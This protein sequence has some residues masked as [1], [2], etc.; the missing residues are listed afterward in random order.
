MD[1]VAPRAR[2]VLMMQIK[3]LSGLGAQC[4]LPKLLQTPSVLSC[5]CSSQLNQGKDG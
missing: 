4:L 3:A 2:A 1:P 5:S